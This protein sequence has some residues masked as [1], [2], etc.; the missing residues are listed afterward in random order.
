MASNNLSCVGRGTGVTNGSSLRM[1]ERAFAVATMVSDSQL[2]RSVGISAS[3]K[4][5]EVE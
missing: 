1:D 5:G 4:R 2:A 3:A